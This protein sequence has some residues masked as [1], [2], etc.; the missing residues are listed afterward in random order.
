[1]DIF[2][3][4]LKVPLSYKPKNKKTDKQSTSKE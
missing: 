1:M 2:P 4:K 3:Q